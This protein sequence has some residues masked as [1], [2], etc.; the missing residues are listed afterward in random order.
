[1]M[2]FYSGVHWDS[3]VEKVSQRSVAQW[4]YSPE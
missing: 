3:D 1:M 2:M 4:I